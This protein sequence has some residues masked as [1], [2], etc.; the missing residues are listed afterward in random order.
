[1]AITF[2]KRVFKRGASQGI[3]LPQSWL[4]YYG[5]RAEEITLMGGSILLVVPSGLEPQAEQLVAQMESMPRLTADTNQE[6]DIKPT[7]EVI[8]T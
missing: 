1:M 8:K 6:S 5:S 7:K 3:S 2:K 4:K